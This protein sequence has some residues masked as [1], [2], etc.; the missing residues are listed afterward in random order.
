MRPCLRLYLASRTDLRR[1]VNF[2]RATILHNGDQVSN[3]RKSTGGFIDAGIHGLMNRM[4]VTVHSEHGI[5]LNCV[6]V[7][8]ITDDSEY[9]V[10][11]NAWKCSKGGKNWRD[12]KSQELHCWVDCPGIPWKDQNSHSGQPSNHDHHRLEWKQSLIFEDCE[13]S[14]GRLRISEESDYFQSS[15]RS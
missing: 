15:S 7:D 14:L 8:A 2:G 10:F 1:F 3:L 4:D 11:T 6:G 13:L 12:G 9:A 5:F